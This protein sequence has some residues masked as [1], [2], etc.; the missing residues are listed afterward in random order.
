M[1][2]PTTVLLALRC[3]HGNPTI[4]NLLWW[5]GVFPQRSF[6]FLCR[7]LL[8]HEW[9]P[10]RMRSLDK[11]SYVWWKKSFWVCVTTSRKKKIMSE[12]MADCFCFATSFSVG[13]VFSCGCLFFFLVVAFLFRLCASFFAWVFSFF[14]FCVG[15]SEHH[16]FSFIFIS[17]KFVAGTTALLV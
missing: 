10:N 1:A 4:N 12:S 11:G 16:S 5:V 9:I 6:P 8:L 15:A 2:Q 7:P 13:P 17:M 14:F 3:S